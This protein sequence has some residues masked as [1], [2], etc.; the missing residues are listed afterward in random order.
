[1]S[2]L[3]SYA[4]RNPRVRG[5]GVDEKIRLN[6]RGFHGGAYVMAFVEDTSECGPRYLPDCDDECPDCPEN[7]EPRTILE[8]SDCEDR[9]NLW[10]EIDSKRFSSEIKRSARF[11]SE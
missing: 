1:M 7:F 6:L 10:F 3:S 8:I 2:Y 5:A 4:T 9:I 11:W